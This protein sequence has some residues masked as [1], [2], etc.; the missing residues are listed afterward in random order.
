MIPCWMKEERKLDER[1]MKQGKYQV[2][3]KKILVCGIQ[4]NKLSLWIL[5]IDNKSWALDY[6]TESFNLV[7]GE[8]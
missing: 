1:R 3:G 6:R 7:R 2:C 4:G 5:L 8:Q